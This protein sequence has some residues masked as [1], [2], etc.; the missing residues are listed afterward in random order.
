MAPGEKLPPGNIL[1]L[2]CL[3]EQQK[4]M[5]LA[6]KIKEDKLKDFTE[7]ESYSTNIVTIDGYEYVVFT[8]GE[9]GIFVVPKIQ[10]LVKEMSP[11]E[12]ET[13]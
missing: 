4:V 11:V 3:V 7:L 9:T 13:K 8:K 2:E 6:E 1:Q 10:P 5:K 12:G